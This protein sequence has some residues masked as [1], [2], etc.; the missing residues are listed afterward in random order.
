MIA[1]ELVKPAAPIGQILLS[2]GIETSGGATICFPFRGGQ[3]GWV[4]QIRQLIDSTWVPLA[5]YTAWIPTTEGKLMACAVAP[6]AGTYA[7]FGNWYPT[8]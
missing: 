8:K 5:T 2:S 4:G 1:K 6:A 7:L 3:F